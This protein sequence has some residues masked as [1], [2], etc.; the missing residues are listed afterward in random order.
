V[1]LKRAASVSQIKI[2]INTIANHYHYDYDQHLI[3]T[4]IKSFIQQYQIR[5]LFK[6]KP[7]INQL[8][9][10]IGLALAGLL[11]HPALSEVNSDNQAIEDLNV[12]VVIGSRSEKKLKDVA[13]SVSVISSDDIEQQAA[14]DL[15]QIFQYEPGV[16]VTGRVGGAQNILVRGM[17]GDRVLLIKDSMRM[18]EGYGANGLND[19]VGRGF[20]DI[21]TLKQ[22]E[23]AKGASSSLYG[24]DALGGVVVFT[25][26]DARDYLSGDSDF[27]GQLKLGHTSYSNQYNYGI[28]L[29]S[30]NGK[31]EH[32]LHSNWRDGEEQQNYLESLSPFSISS[33][34]LIYKGKLN[35]NGSSYLQLSV[36]DWQQ[37]TQ[38]ERAD[39]LLFYF[40]G[41]AEY[42]YNI[43][44]ES[45]KG[46]KES[47]AT[48]LNYHADTIGIIKELNIAFYDTTN[49]QTDIEYGQLDINAP[50]FGIVELRDMWKTGIYQQGTQGLVSSMIISLNAQ[51]TLGMGAD[52][53]NT[54]SLRRVRE[55]R[56]ADGNVIRDNVIE[57]FP[58][59]ETARLGIFISDEMSLLDGKWLI[60]AGARYDDYS[61][62]PNGALKQTGEPFAKIEEDN[63]SFNLG[64][65]YHF[66]SNLSGFLQ[67]GQGFKVPA[68]DLAY[69]EHYLQPT[70]TYAYQ[71]IPSD[72]L[73]PE[74]S[75]TLEMGI[76]FRGDRLSMDASIYHNRFENFLAVTLIDT[77]TL[78]DENGN[79][80]NVLDTFQYQNLESVTIKGIE[81]NASYAF[82]APWVLYF[83]ASY[84]DGKN[85]QTN[86][87]INTISPINGLLGVSY[88]GDRWQLALNGSWARSMSKVNQ[89]EI[90]TPGYGV[91]DLLFNYDISDSVTLNLALNNLFDKLYARHQNLAGRSHTTELTPFTEAGRT[92][93]LQAKLNF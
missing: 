44:Q 61:M 7:S 93:S 53:E 58:T 91:W 74:E 81:M 25:T 11:A 48:R 50:M 69:I 34:N 15:N 73:A 87:Y 43:Q 52:L 59:N 78:F 13:G 77:E 66:S 60:T 1:F 26:K 39:G 45:S 54:E 4:N 82:D 80:L 2:R 56:V 30:V 19:Q 62:D 18:N 84:Q 76:R 6:M 35:F 71:I 38:G 9:L 8:S 27:G 23:V 3:K 37:D 41:L 57:K 89:D 10:A 79:F 33:D 92:F 32:L 12:L 14:T 29:A 42:G 28:S 63:V 51:H 40:R 88:T 16:S 72:D 31:F 83:N 21:D 46:I 65:L 55:Y 5:G 75:D 47:K 24:A 68:Y 49:R 70:S 67:Y 85:D 20:I 90:K 64:S 36:E 86:E 22:V 17:G